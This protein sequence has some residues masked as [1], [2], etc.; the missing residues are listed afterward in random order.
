MKK[1]KIFWVFTDGDLPPQGTDEPLGHE[2]LMVL[3]MNETDAHLL[4]DYYYADKDPK[5]GVKVTIPAS[6]V[7]CL[8][9]D[10]A[11]GEE[12]FLNTHGQYSLVVNSDIPVV[13]VFGRLDR[14]KDMAY[15]PVQGFSL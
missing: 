13:A 3:N 15:Y 2:A 14:R 7:N 8:R 12:Q 4:L 6:R 11:V 5:K 1:G 10:Y 9:L